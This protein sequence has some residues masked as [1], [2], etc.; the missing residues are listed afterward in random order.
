MHI[1]VFWKD[2]TNRISKTEMYYFRG[3]FP[4]FGH[5]GERR[6]IFVWQIQRLRYFRQSRNVPMFCECILQAVI[7]NIYVSRDQFILKRT[8]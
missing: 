8:S 7:M 1:S 3:L 6:E 5:L 2:I 4:M